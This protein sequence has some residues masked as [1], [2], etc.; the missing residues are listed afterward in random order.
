MDEWEYRVEGFLGQT[1]NLRAGLQ[2][3][4]DEYGRQGWELVDIPKW[5]YR[6]FGDP[7]SGVEELEVSLVF[8]RRKV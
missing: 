1:G 7:G 5:D 2:A 4:L 6:S 8:K 3:A